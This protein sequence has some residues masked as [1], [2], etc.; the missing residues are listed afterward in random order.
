MYIDR[1]VDTEVVHTHNEILFSDKKNEIC[2]NM[3]GPRHCHTE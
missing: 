2:S 3:D 1:G